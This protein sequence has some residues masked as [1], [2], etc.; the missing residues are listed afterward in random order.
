LFKAIVSPHSINENDRN[1][2]EG[3]IDD[4]LDNK[5]IHELDFLEIVK[6]LFPE[7][8]QDKD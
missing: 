4:R 1:D 8:P 5:V 7:G 3:N 6:D 2:K